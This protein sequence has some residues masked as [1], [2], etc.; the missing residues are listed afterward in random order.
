MIRMGRKPRFVAS[1]NRRTGRLYFSGW[2]Y[3][4][5]LEGYSHVAVRETP[6][7]VVIRPL[8]KDERGAC[9]IYATNGEATSGHCVIS[10]VLRAADGPERV[11]FSSYVDAGETHTLKEAR[12]SVYLA[13]ETPTAGKIPEVLEIRA[14]G[15]VLGVYALQG[16]VAVERN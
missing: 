3:R 13:A 14:G 8:L 2:Y 1:L 15:K 4:H 9:R 16:G 10:P 5:E 12:R 7:G 6:A 11:S